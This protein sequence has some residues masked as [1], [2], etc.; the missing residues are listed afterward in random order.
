MLILKQSNFR[1]FLPLL[2][3]CFFMI[4]ITISITIREIKFFTL[5]NFLKRRRISFS[6]LVARRAEFITFRIIRIFTF[7]CCG[8]FFYYNGDMRG[9]STLIRSILLSTSVENILN[10]IFDS[11]FFYEKKY[12]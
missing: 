7:S 2:L 6:S 9:N 5:N 12:Y 3:L 8:L 1:R 11:S 10:F 4:M